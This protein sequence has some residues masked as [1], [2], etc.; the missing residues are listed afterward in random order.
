MN[1][2]TGPR[3]YRGVKVP[4]CVQY[5]WDGPAA[6]GWRHGV[7]ASQAPREVTHDAAVAE[8][9]AAARRLN[10][11]ALEARVLAALDWERTDRDASPQEPVRGELWSLLDWTFWGSGM[12]DVFREPLADT[13]LSAI[14]PEQRAQAESLMQSW[15]DSGRQPVGRRLYEELEAEIKELR[16]RVDGGE[17]R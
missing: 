10:S 8:I 2:E 5:A 12:G 1:H 15:H 13:M 9:K 17:D 7:D 11:A 16:V 4:S 14:S 3:E 6:L